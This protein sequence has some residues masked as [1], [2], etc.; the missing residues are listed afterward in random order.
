MKRWAWVV[1]GAILLYFLVRLGV[2]KIR[3]IRNNNPGNL[4][5]LPRGQKWAGELSTQDT[6]TG[7]PFSR[8]ESPRKGWR[9][10]AV[11][12]YGDI[13]RDHLDTI[14]KLVAAYAPAGDL[15]GKQR[16]DPDAYAKSVASKVGISIDF[17]LNVWLHGPALLKSMATVEAGVDPDL[18]WGS[19][20]R[21]DGIMDATDYLQALGRL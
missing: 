16:N 19:K 10:M 1:A 9:A 14:R 17:P 15:A 6:A 3:S 18:V 2:S 13:T 8:F 4:R 7:G 20:E 12:V 21:L 5:P 11:D